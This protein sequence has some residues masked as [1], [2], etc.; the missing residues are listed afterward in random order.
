MTKPTGQRRT[1]IESGDAVLS[2]QRWSPGIALTAAGA[3]VPGYAEHGGRCAEAAAELNRHGYLVEAFDL[4]GHGQSSGK[5]TAIDGYDHYLDDVDA[6][7]SHLR[8]R[9]PALLLFLFGR[10]MGSSVVVR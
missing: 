6:F 1:T 5:R 2:R 3:L 9:N 8:L 10:S 4:R 7:R